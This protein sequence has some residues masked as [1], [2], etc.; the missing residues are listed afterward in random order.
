ME[1]NIMKQDYNSNRPEMNT[2]EY[3]SWRYAV[4]AR[5]NFTCQLTASKTNLEVHHIK[6]WANNEKLRYNVSNGITLCEDAH[7]MVTGNEEQ[8]EEI[9]KE[10]V[11]KN[12]MNQY[13]R[14]G[15]N[16]KKKNKYKLKN[17]RLRY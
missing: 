17:P 15:P 5:D 13:K 6:K 7:A 10:I 9:F 11:K 1:I 12:S 2:P 14:G 8:Y 4:L 16:P 3:K